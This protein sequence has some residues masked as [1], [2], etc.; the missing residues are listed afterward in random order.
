MPSLLSD[1][2]SSDL[3]RRQSRAWPLS[4]FV[5]AVAVFFGY[6]NHSSKK[7]SYST[8]IKTLEDQQ[9]ILALN[10]W[11]VEGAVCDRSQMDRCEPLNTWTSVTLNNQSLIRDILHSLHQRIP[12]TNDPQEVV[13]RVVLSHKIMFSQWLWIE[14]HAPVSLVMPSF[15][16]TTSRMISPIQTPW[17]TTRQSDVIITLPDDQEITS[18]DLEVLIPLE[19][20]WFGSYFPPALVHWEH[21]DE[22]ANLDQ[23]DQFVHFLQRA[24]LVLMPLMTAA[25][26]L[27]L[28]H[29]KT[30]LFVS[31]I[32]V[33]MAARAFLSTIFETASAHHQHLI[34]L[35]LIILTALTPVLII[36]L[37]F[38]LISVPIHGLIF[39]SMGVV[40]SV[41]QLVMVTQYP[42]TIETAH[43]WNEMVGLVGGL[44]VISVGALASKNI[45]KGDMLSSGGYA[46]VI[47][48]G[49]VFGVSGS[50]LI[51]DVMVYGVDTASAITPWIHQ[52]LVPSLFVVSL[53]NIGS[54]FNTI[55]RV[56]AIIKEKTR[57]DRDIE[58]GRK[59]QK[60]ILP[61]KKFN[62]P[63]L[64]WHTFYYP[65]SRLAGDWFDLREITT[66]EGRKLLLGCVVD[67]TGHGISSAMMTSNIASH[68][69]IWC[70]NL[71]SR[72]LSTDSQIRNNILITA[73]QQ[74]HRGLIGLRYNLGCSMAVI[75]IEPDTGHL[76]YLTAG[77]PGIIVSHAD[78]SFQYLTTQG[79]R[80]GITGGTPLWIARSITLDASPKNLIMFTDGVVQEQLTV[81]TWLKRIRRKSQ[82][83]QKSPT[84]YV[85]S[86][87]RANRKLFLKDHQKEDD[88]TV[89][90]IHLKGSQSSS[91]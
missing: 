52:L 76:T 54:V 73:P 19:Q 26:V 13:L 82:T 3:G 53:V 9:K 14:D 15:V 72:A 67:V 11:D 6:A 38:H 50:A 75:M 85:A 56:S 25:L 58:I 55:H 91:S 41:I 5:L 4:V 21:V 47:C 27:I 7:L 31:Y 20:Q 79:T 10:T 61:Q 69:G 86:Q 24:S 48:A 42:T 83:Q 28:D 64:R 30:V 74:I 90:V 39:V 68:W 49:V 37:A 33:V 63:S 22:Y 43:I 80:P 44:I 18:V 8:K 12:D 89:L 45:S 34:S 84:Y 65:A 81:P 60:D 46:S 77:H 62:S 32:G 23:L 40:S 29:A 57:I 51:W 78:H 36:K 1:L 70:E 59:L 71:K 17:N 35:L 66:H 87:L 16:G 2:S 88:L